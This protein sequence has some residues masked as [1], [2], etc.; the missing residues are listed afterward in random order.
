MVVGVALYDPAM[1]ARRT[2]KV[3]RNV[4]DHD[5]FVSF[6]ELTNSLSNRRYWILGMRICCTEDQVYKLIGR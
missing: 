5:G 3:T 4:A 6:Y 2:I 1:R